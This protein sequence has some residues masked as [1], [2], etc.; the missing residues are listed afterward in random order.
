MDLFKMP[1][2]IVFHGQLS[3]NISSGPSFFNI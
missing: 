2:V 1:V 3:Y